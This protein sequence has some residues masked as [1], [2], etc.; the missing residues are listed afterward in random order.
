MLYF[1]IS[2]NGYILE[3]YVNQASSNVRPDNDD[4][5]RD[6]VHGR[7]HNDWNKALSILLVDVEWKE[8]NQHH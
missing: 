2:P 4:G 1:S 3:Y 5:E 7:P 8:I 6:L